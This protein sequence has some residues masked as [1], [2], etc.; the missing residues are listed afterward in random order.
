[1]PKVSIVT[2]SYNQKEFL[3]RCI[4]SVEGQDFDDYEHIVVDAGSSDG[5]RELLD[6]AAARIWKAKQLRRLVEC[7]ASGVVARAA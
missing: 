2:I 7:F 6:G 3:S 4:R 1:M 5:S